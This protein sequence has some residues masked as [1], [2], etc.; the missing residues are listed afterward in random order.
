MPSSDQLT[1]SAA[2]FRGPVCKF[3]DDKC[4]KDDDPDSHP[5]EDI[6]DCLRLEEVLRLVEVV[7]RSHL[8]KTSISSLCVW[9]QQL[10]LY[11]NGN[12]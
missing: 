5:I 10:E 8:E 3:P 12:F 6:D 11:T 2:V 4:Q 1:F 7:H 9:L